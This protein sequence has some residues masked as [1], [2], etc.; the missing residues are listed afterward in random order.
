MLVQYLSMQK[1]DAA[2]MNAMKK[3]VCN[4]PVNYKYKNTVNNNK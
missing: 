1:T 2:T 4:D 3:T